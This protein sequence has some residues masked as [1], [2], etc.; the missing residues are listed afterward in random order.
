MENPAGEKALTPTLKPRNAFI[1]FFLSLIL[2]GLGQVYNGQPKKAIL[3]FG[4]LMLIPLLFGLTNNVTFFYGL[5]TLVLVEVFFRIFVIVDAVRNAKCQN[6]YNLKTY[7]TW[8]YHFFIAIV[9]V[10]ALWMFNTLS[11]LGA[12]TF[13][14]SSESNDPTL[15][16][17]DRVVADT[18]IYKSKDIAYGDLVVF[19]APKGEKWIFR[20][21][22]LP[23]DTLELNENILTINGKQSKAIFIRE[24]TSNGFPISEFIEKF[25]NG[26]QHHIFK[27]KKPY[28]STKTTI[29][30]IVVPAG[31]YYLLADNRDN[32]ADSRYIGSIKR[33]DILGQIM[34]SYWGK[35]TDRINIDFR[36]K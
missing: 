14:M 22:G 10:A 23:N 20:V 4:L 24:T 15:Q 28:D 9:M 5:V 16:V 11:I 36:G 21:A 18:K 26:H 1:A 32:A 19:N 31:R 6:Q 34:Y 33:N 13:E 3:F 7:N 25:P 17:G 12:Q 8:F 30:N 35:T 2:P 29:K 27:F